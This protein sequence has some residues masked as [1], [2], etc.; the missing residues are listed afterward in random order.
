MLLR[1][2]A[3]CALI[4]V[5]SSATSQQ[6][7]PVS[8]CDPAEEAFHKVNTWSD[9]REWE[10]QFN[11]CDD[12]FI[13]EAIDSKVSTLL[14]SNWDLLNQLKAEIAIH[15]EF[16]AQVFRHLG[17]SISCSDC[18][19]IVLNAEARCPPQCEALCAMIAMVLRKDAV[20]DCLPQS[21]KEKP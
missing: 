4:A 13:A 3:T 7:K 19:L 15:K 2:F 16:E 10:A 21:A 8:V 11:A 17:E 14:T 1:A 9:L 20:P 18:K 6:P 12:G 5:C